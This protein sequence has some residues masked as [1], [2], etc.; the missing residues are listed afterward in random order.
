MEF[1]YDVPQW[2]RIFPQE[3]MFYSPWLGKRKSRRINFTC[4]R[5]GLPFPSLP[6]VCPLA[7]TWDKNNKCLG[8]AFL[9]FPFLSLPFHSFSLPIRIPRSLS[10]THA[11]TYAICF[12][13]QLSQRKEGGGIVGERAKWVLTGCCGA[14]EWGLSLDE[15]VW[16]P[17]NTLILTPTHTHTLAG[18]RTHST[19]SIHFPICLSFI[20]ATRHDYAWVLYSVTWTFIIDMEKKRN[21]S[22]QRA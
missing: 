12:S 11:A 10:P 4:L 2:S 22:S 16:Q 18:A 21:G 8:N 7:R 1:V 9:S 14:G 3:S 5:F 6:V 15:Y 17:A 19:N 20:G 13:F